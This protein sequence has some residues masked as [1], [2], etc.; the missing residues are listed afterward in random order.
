MRIIVAL[1]AVAILETTLLAQGVAA[2]ASAT[3]DSGIVVA[4][5]ATTFAE[6]YAREREEKARAEERQ[7]FVS[8]VKR[9]RAMSQAISNQI[10]SIETRMASIEGHLVTVASVDPEIDRLKAEREATIDKAEKTAREW[11]TI[12]QTIAN[13]PQTFVDFLT[14]KGIRIGVSSDGIKVSAPEK[15]EKK[16]EQKTTPTPTP[17]QPESSDGIAGFFSGE[18]KGGVAALIAMLIAMY[19]KKKVMEMLANNVASFDQRNEKATMAAILKLFRSGGGGSPPPPP[20][21]PVAPSAPTYQ[22]QSKKPVVAAAASIPDPTALQ[23]GE[24]DALLYDLVSQRH[25]GKNGN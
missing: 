18:V 25:A 6:A 7:R 12:E 5:E 10:E 15:E 14:G 8:N 20:S 21:P 16:P 22:P 3:A 13:I 17:T 19:G 2:K 24:W 23:S 1:L 9:W 4:P 11:A